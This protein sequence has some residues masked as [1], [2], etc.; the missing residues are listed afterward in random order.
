MGITGNDK[1]LIKRI[2]LKFNHNFFLGEVFDKID[3]I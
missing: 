1:R 3:D 2:F